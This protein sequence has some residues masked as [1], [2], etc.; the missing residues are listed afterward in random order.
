MCICVYLWVCVLRGQR[1]ALDSLH[2]CKAPDAGAGNWTQEPGSLG[3]AVSVFNSWDIFP[4]PMKWFLKNDLFTIIFFVWI[5]TCMYVPGTC[6]DQK[7]VSDP[8][9][10]GSAVTENCINEAFECS[11]ELLWRSLLWSLKASCTRTLPCKPMQRCC[12]S[13]P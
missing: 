1:R 7:K 3:R 12:L 11:L 5:F 13:I 2:S 9:E 8:L 6:G 10:L 4:A